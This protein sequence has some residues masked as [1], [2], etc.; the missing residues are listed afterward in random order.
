MDINKIEAI[1][2]IIKPQKAKKLQQTSKVGRNDSVQ[3]S[4]EAKEMA[5]LEKISNIVK[6]SPDMRMDK[7]A[8][9]KEKIKSGNY[10][11]KK[12]A[13]SIADKILISLGE[14]I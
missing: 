2:E 8:A 11:N 3:I 5:E 12:V 6:K 1:K 9:A 10:F 13:E 4:S 14:K 7:I